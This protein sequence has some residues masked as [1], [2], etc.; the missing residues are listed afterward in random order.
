MHNLV[1]IVLDYFDEVRHICFIGSVG[2]LENRN[3]YVKSVKLFHTIKQQWIINHGIIY[4]ISNHG[5]IY[6]SHPDIN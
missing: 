5:I 6:V 1:Y 2:L 4:W 3:L